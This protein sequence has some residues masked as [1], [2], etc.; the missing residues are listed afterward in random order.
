MELN[1]VK[2]QLVSLL[3]NENEEGII[4]IGGKG[5]VRVRGK[6]R[7]VLISEGKN[8]DIHSFGSEKVP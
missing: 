1:I 5:V 8:I 7:I 6:A 3:I 4:R 2:E